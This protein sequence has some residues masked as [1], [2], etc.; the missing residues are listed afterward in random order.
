NECMELDEDCSLNIWEKKGKSDFTLNKRLSGWLKQDF[1]FDLM[2]R[3]P[4][5]DKSFQLIALAA[6]TIDIWEW[7]SWKHLSQINNLGWAQSCELS[8]KT[9]LV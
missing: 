6:E 8:G 3:K 9:L 5:P 7:N 1:Y 2:I 4:F